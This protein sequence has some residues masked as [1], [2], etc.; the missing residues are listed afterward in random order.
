M[1]R[2][3]EVPVI[4]QQRNIR[5]PDLMIERAGT[6]SAERTLPPLKFSWRFDHVFRNQLSAFSTPGKIRPLRTLS[7]RLYSVAY[8]GFGLQHAAVFTVRLE[9]L[10]ESSRRKN[11]CPP[12]GLRAIHWFFGHSFW[13][14]F[15]HLRKDMLIP[16]RGQVTVHTEPVPA[17][18][19]DQFAHG[20]GPEFNPVFDPHITLAGNTTLCTIPHLRHVS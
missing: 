13:I 12:P 20:L 14:Y 10:Q 1:I 17:D 8:F 5:Q 4:R 18:R 2:E 7:T 3:G 16:I 15:P 9:D 19:L 11:C 6:D